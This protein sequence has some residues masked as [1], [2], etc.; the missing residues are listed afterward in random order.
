VR[1]PSLVLVV[2]ALA[3][4]GGCDLGSE[5]EEGSEDR[6]PTTEARSERAEARLVARLRRGGNVL[7]FRHAATDSSMD[8]TSDLSDCSRQRNLNGEGRRQS[9]AI[10]RAIRRLGVPVG[11]V[12]ASPFC[13]TRETARLA[14]G[15]FR[16]SRDLLSVEFFEDP[17]AGGKRPKGLRRLLRKRPGRGTNTMLVSHSSAIFGATGLDPEE[18]EVLVVAPGRGARGFKVVGRV[19]AGEWASLAG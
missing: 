11:Q 6:A 8:T 10:G 19:Q 7:A 9:R 18:G 12:L 4:A 13:R 15:R 5:D 3:V 14:F 2:A 1:R 17:D 16:P